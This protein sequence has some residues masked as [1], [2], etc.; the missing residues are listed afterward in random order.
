VN[1][2]KREQ[3]L[4]EVGSDP[5]AYVQ[6]KLEEALNDPQFLAKAL[7]KARG[8][9]SAQPTQVKLPPSLNKAASARTDG[10]N[11]TSDQ[12]MYRH[13]IGR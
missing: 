6:K 12:G 9:A 2:Y 10:D 1:W 3:T 4:K 13:A 7:E 11:D 8:A 5:N